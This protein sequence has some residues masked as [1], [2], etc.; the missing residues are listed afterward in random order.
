MPARK[1]KK[2]RRSRTKR[3]SQPA[4]L[5]L[6]DYEKILDEDIFTLLGLKNLPAKKKQEIG[7]KIEDILVSKVLLRLSASLSNP[8]IAEVKRMLEENDQAGL[9]QFL[10]QK[11]IDL[12]RLFIEEAVLLKAH[13]VQLV[14]NLLSQ[15]GS[16]N[17]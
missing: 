1:K 17:A 9:Q 4:L 3:T 15:S 12:P 14:K 10:L 6:A 5:K 7:D 2:T 11:G 8:E 13:L 16:T